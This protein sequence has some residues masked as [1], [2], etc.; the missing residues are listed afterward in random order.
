MFGYSYNNNNNNNNNNSIDPYELVSTF[1]AHIDEW[2]IENL[3][4]DHPEWVKYPFSEGSAELL[5]RFSLSPHV[6]RMLALMRGRMET[7]WAAKQRARRLV[8]QRDEFV[9]MLP[10]EGEKREVIKRR[11]MAVG[12][13]EWKKEILII[14]IINIIMIMDR[15]WR[16]R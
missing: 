1:L 5:F 12:R 15:S 14:I 11:I 3:V 7:E 4:H 10:H 9:L 6:R 13:L 2:R 16:E 8:I